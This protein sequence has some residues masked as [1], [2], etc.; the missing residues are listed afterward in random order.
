MNK[1]SKLLLY[2][3]A[4]MVSMLTSCQKEDNAIWNDGYNV[5][6]VKLDSLVLRLNFDI[7]MTKAYNLIDIVNDVNIFVY[8]IQG[9]LLYHKYYSP[10]NN[11]KIVTTTGT[12]TIVA[13]A[14]AGNK[15][16]SQFTTLESLRNSKHTEILGTNSSI[17]YAG[18]ITKVLSVQDK[19]IN[20][21]IKR[22]LSKLTFVFDKSQLDPNTSVLI[23]RIQLKNVPGSCFYIKPNTPLSADIVTNGDFLE[24]NLEPANHECAS[25][26]YMFENM[27]GTVGTTTNPK[28]KSPGNNVDVCSYVE[29]TANY[30]N[31]QKS[32]IIKYRMFLGENTTTNFD[33]TRETH[34]RETI[35]FNGTTIT[36]PSWMVDIGELNYVNYT[37]TVSANPANG[38]IVDGNGQ[39][40]YGSYPC[41]LAVPNEDY[42]FNGWSPAITAVT[43]NQH[44]TA[45]F[46]YVDVPVSS[47]SLNPTTLSFTALEA[48]SALTGTYYPSTATTGTTITYSS[49]NTAIATVNSISG[50]VT[51]RGWGNCTITATSSNN[52]TATCSVSV[53]NP[54]VYVNSISVSIGSVTIN[55]GSTT[56]ATATISPGNATNKN[57]IWSSSNTSV[58]TVNNSGM[59]TAAASGTCNIIATA[60]DGTGVT[61]LAPLTVI[62]PDVAVTGVTISI[63]TLQ[64]EEGENYTLTATVFPENATNKNVM[65][66]S[67]DNSVATVNSSGVVTATG[68]GTVNITATTQDGGY[69]AICTVTVYTV[70]WVKT[71]IGSRSYWD[72]EDMKEIQR[73]YIFYVRLE[74]NDMNIVQ[75]AASYVV[76]SISYQL[77]A[78]QNLTGTIQLNLNPIDNNEDAWARAE[79]GLHDMCA[80]IGIIDR[81][82]NDYEVPNMYVSES[83]SV[84]TGSVIVNNYKIKWSNLRPWGYDRR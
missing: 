69:T 9:Q 62:R 15:D 79:E 82:I 31:P 34:Y 12:K 59:V 76:I 40:A 45:N 2:S 53:V 60:Q 49:N 57:V 81:D 56:T 73:E 6:V 11:M 3:M 35:I 29:I 64:M 52:K 27:Q 38:G 20:V 54:I 78:K 50:V 17:V 22:M 26:L 33:V 24:N 19:S 23:K 70:I 30:T 28:A 37:V 58:A 80:Y 77:R 74:T 83:A 42:I 75:Q 13:I 21:S 61:G 84:V 5:V 8:G 39:Y 7:P 68:S 32:G 16:F 67:S 44:Y 4:A 51:S 47:I 1:L 55:T 66:I 10:A 25:P 71:F 41:L 14:N 48:C 63:S 36:E 18:E 46:Q 65:W 72:N 43:S